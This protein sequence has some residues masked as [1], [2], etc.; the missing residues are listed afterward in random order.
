MFYLS[1]DDLRKLKLRLAEVE[2][3]L[4][5]HPDR[6]ED[7]VS[8][9]TPQFYWAKVGTDPIPA[10][11]G[12]TPGSLTG[13]KI[14]RKDEDTGDFAVV[15]VGGSDYEETVLNGWGTA[16]G[17]EVYITIFRDAFGDLWYLGEDC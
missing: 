12:D 13:V 14:Y 3:L 11:S 1:E 10:R 6:D 5:N 4:R 2:R 8:L 15:Q 9:D 7:V 17:T 16:S